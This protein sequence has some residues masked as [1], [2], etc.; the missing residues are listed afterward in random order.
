[1][2][3]RL[4]LTIAILLT[5]A[6]GA[7]ADYSGSCG[8]SVTYSYVESTRT[9]TIS[10]TGD[11]ADYYALPNVPWNDYKPNI[12]T[13]VIGDG[14]TRIGKLAFQNCTSLTSATIPNSVTSIGESAFEG[15]TSLASVAIPSKV[16]MT[17]SYAFYGCTSLTSVNI[18]ASLTSIGDNS[19]TGCSALETITVDAGNTVYDS[20]DNC[21]AIIYNDYNE[22]IEKSEDILLYGC[23]NTVIPSG[24]TKIGAESFY[25]CTGLTSIEIPGS[26]TDIG[27]YAFY[28]CT[29]LSSIEIPE[30]VTTI[31]SNAFEGCTRLTS[32]EIPASVT[33]IGAKAFNAYTGDNVYVVVPEGK[34]LIVTIDGVTDP[35]VIEPT[36]GKADILDCLFA[37][38]VD[39]TTSRALIL[40]NV[41]TVYVTTAA[42]EGEA[43]NVEYFS[44]FFVAVTAANAATSDVTVTLLDDVDLDETGIEFN[45]IYI[46]GTGDAE[47]KVRITL[48]LNGHCISGG[49]EHETMIKNY[50]LLTIINSS[51]D[52]GSFSANTGVLDIIKNEDGGEVSVNGVTFTGGSTYAIDNDGFLTIN[53]M[54]ITGPSKGI[55]SYGDLILNGWPTFSTTALDIYLTGDKMITFGD[56]FAVPATEYSPIKVNFNDAFPRAITSG[57]AAHCKDGNGNV[58]D[59]ADVF[60]ISGANIVLAGGE[61]VAYDPDKPLVAVNTASDGSIT[62]LY[63]KDG[64]TY[65]TDAAALAAAVDALADG[66]TLTLC[67]D[68]IGVET[69]K[70]MKGTATAPVTLDLNGKT[71]SGDVDAVIWVYGNATLM[72]SSTGGGGKISN[73]K[74]NADYFNGITNYGAVNITGCTVET[75]SPYASAIAVLENGTLSANGT[76]F[77][78]SGDEGNGVCSFNQVELTNCTMSGTFRGVY[79]GEGTAT[80]TGGSIS[81]YQHAGIFAEE[82]TVTLTAWPTFSGNDIDIDLKD[83][84]KIVLGEGFAVPATVNS[85]IKVNA[86]GDVPFPITSGYAAHCKDGNGNVLDPAK[87]FKWI[88]TGDYG[89][90][91]ANAVTDG[92]N[93]GDASETPEAYIAAATVTVGEN[94]YAAASL[95]AAVAAANAAT[96]DCTVTLLDDV[97]LGATYVTFNNTN[98]VGSGDDEHTVK[99]TLDLNGKTITGSKLLVVEIAEGADVAIIDG[100]NSATAGII[101]TGEADGI[102]NEGTLAVSG[103]AISG[104]LDGLNIQGGAAVVTNC[105]INGNGYYGILNFGYLTVSGGTV[106]GKNSGIESYQKATIS[107]CVISGPIGIINYP[108]CELT[109]GAGVTIK[110][111]TT[112][113]IL[114]YGSLKLNVLP[115]FTGATNAQCDIV[116]AAH[117]NTYDD[118]PYH[119]YQPITFGTGLAKPTSPVSVKVYDYDVNKEDY[120]EAALPYVFTKGYA[121]AFTSGNPA[122]VFT[123]SGATVQLVAGEAIAKADGMEIV[124]YNTDIDG[125]ITGLYAVDGTTYTTDAAALTAAV[126]AA[127]AATGDVTVTLLDDVDL[128][129]TVVTFNNTN[130]VGSGD[131]QR[132]VKITLDLNGKTITGSGDKAIEIAAGTDVTI[133]SSAEGGKVSNGAY[134]CD[135]IANSGTLTVSG[136]DIYGSQIGIYNSGTLTVTDCNVS[137]YDGIHN[138]GE[139]TVSGGSISGSNNGIFNSASASSATIE[140]VTIKSSSKGILAF[141]D[142]TLTAWPTFSGNGTDITLFD[143]AKIVLGDGFKVPATEYNKIKITVKATGDDPLTIPLTITSGYAAHCKDGQN[144]VLDPYDVFTLIDE[145]H[146]LGLQDGEVV[147][148]KIPTMIT[149]EKDALE[150]VV[151]DEVSA[152]ATLTP[153]DAGSLVYTSSNESVAIVSEGKIKAL[154]EGTATITVSFA[155]NDTYAAAESKTISIAVSLNETSVSVNDLPPM[156]LS[157]GDEFVLV[158]TTTP[159]GMTVTFIPDNSGV[160]SVDENGVVT[161]LKDGTAE[162]TVTVGDGKVYAKSSTTVTLTVSTYNMDN[163]FVGDNVWTGF[164]AEKDLRVPYG[165]TAYVVTALGA[166]TATASPIEYIPKDVPVLL[167]REDKTVNSYKTGEDIGTPPDV[168]L[169]QV[170]STTNQPKALRDY[171][172][173]QDAFVLVSGGT[174]ATGKVFLPVPQNQSRAAARAIVID[175]ETTSLRE[176]DVEVAESEEWFDLQGR[177]L[178]G[179]PTRKGVYIHNGKKEVVR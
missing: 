104:N 84:L 70:I 134:Q 146:A 32:I 68:V 119:P 65:T 1:M 138:D 142:V 77:K 61:A 26:V 151:L 5:A 121:A 87:V 174:L 133:V 71:I 115:T 140:A 97:D 64:T 83:G 120:V 113:G 92:T 89:I 20:R 106:S 167:K 155:G 33:S 158:P 69:I 112:C 27:N 51:T 31:W 154:G 13:V 44:D 10:G 129:A 122:E 144:N 36:E 12:S 55:Q 130:T 141:A 39:R 58:L 30:G 124:A 132:T 54:K 179:K 88:G 147:V 125:I 109:I 161:A 34:Q 145:Y 169:L 3:K 128:G 165:L 139:M 56:D 35:V 28:G 108:D 135:G 91:L 163:L 116:L 80:I 136:I 78:A 149:I 99:I 162:I 8:T 74:T 19:F 23:K 177:K 82:G 107:G 86:A 16:S 166:E 96:S 42:G 126:T 45:N 137:G 29:G 9:L 41:I 90:T 60:T 170:A 175:G 131:D 153:A 6:L 157:V 76:T 98:T 81:G 172:L 67:K 25:G 176:M 94:I 110:D 14:V 46:V 111:F 123:V 40:S 48:D 43:P 171:V 160:V 143:G 4:L 156:A 105:N 7:R 62:G 17:G 11:M 103:I 15:C 50:G 73:T 173:Y 66:E 118:I 117:Y 72:I 79:V 95:A 178:D 114:A 21:N 164:V 22:I 159:D 18:P 85:P 102:Y 127:N 152:G 150:L 168:N 93:F 100:A 47:R 2:E 75:A 49:E 53:D 52:T 148:V 37:D 63:A 57:Y 24:V 59:P 38:P 101:G